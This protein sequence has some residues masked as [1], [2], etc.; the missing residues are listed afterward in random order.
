MSTQ[1]LDA[2][3]DETRTCLAIGIAKQMD[4]KK[5]QAL[6]P[7]WIVNACAPEPNRWGQVSEI[8]GVDQ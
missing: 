6:I 7:E 3:D 8:T 2:P 5:F 1:L 4:R